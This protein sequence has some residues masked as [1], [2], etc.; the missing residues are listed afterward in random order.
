MTHDY[1]THWNFG[2]SWLLW[3][4]VWFLLISS[5]GHWGYAY[6]VNQRYLVPPAKNAL[7]ILNERYVRG[8]IDRDEYRRMKQEMAAK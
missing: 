2:W 1:M 6:R 5:F 7:D 4:G 3:F 8:D